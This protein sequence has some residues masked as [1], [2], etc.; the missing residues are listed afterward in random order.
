MLITFSG[1]DGAGKST[2][3]NRL[4]QRLDDGKGG[5]IYL[6]ARGGYTPGFEFLKLLLRIF[7]GRH[8]LPSGHSDVR[9]QRLANRFLARVWLSVAMVD[10][11]IYWGFFLRFQLL[12]GRTVVCDRYLQDTLLDFRCNFQSIPFET[13]LLWGFL[14][15]LV[16]KPS[17]SFLLWVPV[18][19]SMRRSIEKAEPYPDS[20][21]L[22]TWR[23][24]S[25]MDNSI[26][27]T[28]IYYKVDCRKS[29]DKIS[30]LIAEIIF[31]ASV[32]T[33]PQ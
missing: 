16:P 15:W 11:I 9:S 26:F 3:I 33:P 17:V 29:I 22:L 32:K 1:P 12:L 14:K 27:P 23:L 8:L 6:W 28:S 18:A 20:E 7:F 2:Q 4:L 13:G 21:L 19:Y 30:E 10:L 25:Y 24:Q 5:V 31:R